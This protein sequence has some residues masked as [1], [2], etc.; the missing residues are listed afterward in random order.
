LAAGAVVLLTLLNALTPYTEVKTAYGFNMYANLVTAGGESNHFVVP[1]T[2]RL[3]HDYDRPVEIIE[4]NDAG[5]EIYRERG[6]LVA[7]PQFRRYVALKPD[8][9]VL[10]ERGG[11]SYTIE[12]TNRPLELADPG[13]W[14]WRYLPLRALDTQSP[15]RCQDVFLPAL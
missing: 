13:P 5:L 6:Y 12:G 9:T 2:F 11:E 10:Y 8:V 15:P 4:S 7:Y 1:R 14:W 3:R